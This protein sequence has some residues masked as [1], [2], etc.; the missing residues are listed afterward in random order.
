ML[1]HKIRGL[2]VVNKIGNLVGIVSEG[3]FLLRA[4]TDTERK[5]PRWLQLLV[6]PGR[7]AGD[8]VHT[9]GRR[10]EEVMMAHVVTVTE[11]TPHDEVVALMEKYHQC[12]EHLRR[13]L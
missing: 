7:L 5:R 13:R 4:E 12:P 8:Y 9:H 11:N 10:V 2:P 3:D 6:G 1:R